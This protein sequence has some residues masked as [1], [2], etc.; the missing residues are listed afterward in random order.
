MPE[1]KENSVV[2]SAATD[3]ATSPVALAELGVH[4]GDMV[5]LAYRLVWNL[6]D[7]EDVVHDAMIAAYQSGGQLRNR[8]K[9]AGWLRSIV[10]R[11]CRDL[12]RRDRIQKRSRARLAE[13]VRSVAEGDAIV[14]AN[15]DRAMLRRA[16]AELPV[17]QQTAL[18]LRDLEQLSYR[19]AADLME[20]SQSTVRVLVRNAREGLR[21][22][23]MQE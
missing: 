6:E 5:R 1:S 12:I 18:V 22:R 3:K 9:L 4:R 8:D 17:R 23:L 2:G 11:R 14:E 7:A 16:I 10:V 21:E 15:E 20:V 19:E 13:N